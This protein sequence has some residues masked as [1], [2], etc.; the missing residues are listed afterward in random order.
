VPTAIYKANAFKFPEDDPNSFHKLNILPTLLIPPVLM[1]NDD[2]KNPFNDKEASNIEA[3][4]FGSTT[5]D[6][7]CCST[8]V[9]LPPPC[10]TKVSFNNKSYSDGTYKDNAVHIM[11]IAGHD[12]NHPSPIDP[13]PYMHI[14]GVAMLHYS[15]PNIIGTVFTQSYRINTGLKKFRK[16]GEKAAMI[17]LTQLHDYTTYPLVQ[18]SS[19][20]PEDC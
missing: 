19:F 10:I 7:L 1:M 14:L 18:A 4:V 6:G 13:D 5:I 11:V 9:P 8:R 17:E 16:I 12:N 15:N 2:G 3:A 20:S